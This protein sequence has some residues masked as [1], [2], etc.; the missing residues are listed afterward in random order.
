MEDGSLFPTRVALT[1]EDAQS[2]VKRLLHE[3]WQRSGISKTELA[4]RMGCDEGEAR[5]LLNLDHRSKIHTLNRGA[6]A[7]GYRLSLTIE[8]IAEA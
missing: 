5:R 2:M 8:P 1:E 3:A 4:R 6:Q 7:L